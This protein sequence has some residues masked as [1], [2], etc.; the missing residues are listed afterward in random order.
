[1]LDCY[2]SETNRYGT[3]GY[4]YEGNF[5]MIRPEVGILKGLSIVITFGLGKTQKASLEWKRMM[6]VVKSVIN[7][8]ITSSIA[9]M[10]TVMPCR[11]Q[12]LAVP[13]HPMCPSVRKVQLEPMELILLDAGRLYKYD[14]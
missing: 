1:M 9:N 12:R 11:F 2:I 6:I 14:E 4:V 7:I 5:V 3:D 13:R 8:V 10:T